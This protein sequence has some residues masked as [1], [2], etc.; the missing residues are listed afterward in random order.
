M[1]APER[2]LLS[3]EIDTLRVELR[4]LSQQ[5]PATSKKKR[6]AILQEMWELSGRI[7]EVNV[8]LAQG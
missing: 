6:S 2:Q 4:E 1:T 3:D 5:L 8:R 7:A